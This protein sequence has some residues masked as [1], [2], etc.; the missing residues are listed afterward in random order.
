MAFFDVI[1]IGCCAFDFLLI[2]PEKFKLDARTDISEFAMQGGG[3][4]GT[5]LVTLARLGAK[6]LYLGKLADDQFGHFLYEDFKKEGVDTGR[7]IF[8]KGA[9]STIAFILVHESTGKRTIFVPHQLNAVHLYRGEINLEVVKSTRVL[10]I[11]SFYPEVS[12][13]A[14]EIAKRNGVMVVLGIEGMTRQTPGLI[15]SSDVFIGDEEFLKDFTGRRNYLEGIKKL[16]AKYKDKIIVVTVGTQGSYVAS[17]NE[18]FHTPAFRVRAKD[19]TGAGD[20]Y[21]AAFI[22]G[23]LKKWDLHYTARFASATAALKCLSLG[24]R[25]GIPRLHE[26]LKFMEGK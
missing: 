2:V 20:V 5:G 14:A 10:Y 21:H 17:G 6:T 25:Q 9:S 22:Y 15:K 11:D 26:V 4:I 12:R 19:T 3:P 13:D 16:Q 8:E 23:L 18:I 24:G 1:G 7:I